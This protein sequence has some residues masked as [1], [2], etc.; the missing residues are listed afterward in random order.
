MT[1]EVMITYEQD[2]RTKSISISKEYEIICENSSDRR[3]LFSKNGT[4]NI[5]NTSD[6]LMSHCGFNGPD[7]VC[8][9]EINNYHS[10]KYRSRYILKDESK[11]VCDSNHLYNS[12]VKYGC[13]RFGACGYWDEKGKLIRTMHQQFLCKLVFSMKYYR[14]L[15]YDNA[16][17][18]NN[19]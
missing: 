19:S 16:N 15:F 14:Q 12:S 9:Y 11:F 13:C 1:Q 8:C 5:N 18:K 6:E 10:T 7:I 4:K 17:F 2:C 3:I